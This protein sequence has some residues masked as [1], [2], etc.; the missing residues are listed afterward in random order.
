MLTYGH[1]KMRIL[2]FGHASQRSDGFE[3]LNML[4]RG[5]WI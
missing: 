5:S 3:F 4:P 1:N 2:N